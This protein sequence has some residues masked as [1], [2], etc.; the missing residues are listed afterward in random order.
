MQTRGI[1]QTT[2]LHHHVNPP[3]HPP[4]PHLPHAVATPPCRP[5]HT[6]IIVTLTRSAASLISLTHLTMLPQN[7]SFSCHS[8]HQPTTASCSCPSGSC[9][10][11]HITPMSIECKGNHQQPIIAVCSCLSSKSIERHGNLQPPTTI[12]CCCVCTSSAA[13]LVILKSIGH[14]WK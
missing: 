8:H 9:L 10:A 14:K 7:A 4:P 6:F 2:S 5:G 1:P 12:S 3:V 11:K 13:P